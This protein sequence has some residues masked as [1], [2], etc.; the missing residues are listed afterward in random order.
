[1]ILLV[2]NEI[3]SKQNKVQPQNRVSV[4][5]LEKNVMKTYCITTKENI[6]K[7]CKSIQF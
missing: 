5:K 6:T 7:N 1:M 2:I 3:M 4:Q